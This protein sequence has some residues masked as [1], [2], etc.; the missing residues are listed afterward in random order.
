EKKTKNKTK[1]KEKKVD[2]GLE[3][4]DMVLE[5]EFSS[6]TQAVDVDAVDVPNMDVALTEILYS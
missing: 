6:E 2:V 5:L 1:W 4:V 3:K